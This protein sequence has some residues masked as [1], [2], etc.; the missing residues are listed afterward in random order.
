[1][2]KYII[3]IDG[4]GTKTECVVAD[5]SGK[6]FHSN[7]GKPSNFLAIG[8][9]AAV[10]N[11]FNLVESSLFKIEANFTEIEILLIGTAG[12]GRKK[13][14]TLLE[15][16]FIEYAN[17]EGIN[18]NSV[19]IVSDAQIALEG[20]FSG[21]PGCIIIAGTGS[22]IIGKDNKGLIHRSGGFGRLIGDEGSGYSIG[23]KA[24][25]LTAKELDGY[26]KTTLI[27]KLICTK[28]KVSSLQ[29]LISTVYKKDFDIASVAT[30]VLKAANENNA[31]AIQILNEEADELLVQFRSL[32]KKMSMGK[33]ELVFSGSLISNNNIY[34]ELL[35]KKIA[36]NFPSVKIKNP[37]YSPVE[38]AI[39]L[40]KDILNA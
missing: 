10:R 30:L 24:L 39:A 2:M 29:D 11:L 8:I 36:K 19:K 18:I 16:K 38:G 4:G 1:M 23:K 22:I 12:A 17:T 35:S 6:I 3:G 33:T 25:S 37:D 14:A 20:A 21:K 26:Y 7:L 28:F 13:D 9:D 27:S 34:S 32:L 5:L 31:T 40:A 15:D